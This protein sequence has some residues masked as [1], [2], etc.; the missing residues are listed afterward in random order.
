M[1]ARQTFSAAILFVSLSAC[2]TNQPS[3]TPSAADAFFGANFTCTEQQSLHIQYA[4]LAKHQSAYKDRCVKVEG[5]SNGTLIGKDAS[6]FGHWEP[7][8]LIGLYWQTN[9]VRQRLWRSPSFVNIV[10][11]LR[12]CSDVGKY[13][14]ERADEE[15]A[16]PQPTG[17][18]QTVS[19]PTA[20]G[21]C[22]FGKGNA[23]F[24]TQYTVIPTAMD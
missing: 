2:N 12:N 5:F 17:G 15:N 10:A 8:A 23:L 13:A 9:D 6:V 22:H 7:E 11:R 3:S 20:S 1:G 18:I 14:A 16:R 24:V 19:I 21:I 4:E